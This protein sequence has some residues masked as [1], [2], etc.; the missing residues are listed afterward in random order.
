MSDTS[1]VEDL[2][3]ELVPQVLGMLMR[4]HAR[5][6]DCEDAVQEAL[7]AAAVQWTA[8]GIPDNPQSWLLTVASRRLVDQWRSERARASLS[9]V[10][11]T[12]RQ[13]SRGGSV[14]SESD[15]YSPG[16]WQSQRQVMLLH[17]AATVPRHR[18][19]QANRDRHISL[20]RH[21]VNQSST[22]GGLSDSR[23][24]LPRPSGL[25]RSDRTRPAARGMLDAG[26]TGHG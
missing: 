14:M 6:L 8:S 19:P 26:Q 15:L 20:P 10:T 9:S 2:L 5:F 18:R 11:S 1:R 13:P 22:I 3:R 7:V 24:G 4:R 23:P 12:P 17:A 25:H 16:S 21:P